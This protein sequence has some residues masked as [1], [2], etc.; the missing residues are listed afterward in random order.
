M[1]L[2]H[3]DRGF[4]AQNYVDLIEPFHERLTPLRRH[5]EFRAPALRSCDGTHTTSQ[6]AAVPYHAEQSHFGQEQCT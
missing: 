5:R 1:S 6:I 2:K 3:T 4:H